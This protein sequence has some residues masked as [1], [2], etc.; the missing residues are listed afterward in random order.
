M[1]SVQTQYQP[2]SQGVITLTVGRRV[3]RPGAIAP[4]A[5]HLRP[6]DDDR[7][8][9]CASL[10]LRCKTPHTAHPVSRPPAH[11]AER[12]YPQITLHDLRPGDI[13]FELKERRWS[14]RHLSIYAGQRYAKCRNPG[15]IHSYI[16]LG[17]NP[18]AGTITAADGDSL[19]GLRHTTID[20]DTRKTS[21][22]LDR[23]AVYLFLRMR[24]AT[25]AVW[26]RQ[27]A[28]NWAP[29]GA[30]NFSFSN[31]TMSVFRSPEPTAKSDAALLH[32][33]DQIAV[34]KPPVDPGNPP[35]THR[36]MCSEFVTTVG[37]VATMG[38]ARARDGVR[39]PSNK[40]DLDALEAGPGGHIFAVN[41]RG[42]PPARLYNAMIVDNA[43]HI[44]GYVPPRASGINPF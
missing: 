27:I 15:I 43:A 41:P 12:D 40:R 37:C 5:S 22:T 24:D 42:N 16:V 34:T 32:L 7:Y 21:L 14:F 30:D 17:T 19:T 13:C 28:H 3:R 33:L 9:P 44:V 29:P 31:A 10:A 25:L 39:G 23:H 4:H 18:A 26:M 2:S 6:C 8:A 20:F 36:M 35:K 11:W 1:Q 38:L